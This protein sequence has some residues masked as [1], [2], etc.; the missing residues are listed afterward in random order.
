MISHQKCTIHCVLKSLRIVL[1]CTV[2]KLDGYVVDSCDLFSLW[3]I[4][5]AL[6]CNWILFN[7]YIKS[8]QD[9]S[10]KVWCGQRPSFYILAFSPFPPPII[11]PLIFLIVIKYTLYDIYHF[12]MNKLVVLCTLTSLC[13]HHHQSPWFL[14]LWFIF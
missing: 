12:N 4:S 9:R 8:F 10:L 6:F 14:I 13:N 7:T 5:R 1:L 2:S 3:F 11:W